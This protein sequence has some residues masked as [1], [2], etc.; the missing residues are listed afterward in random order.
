MWRAFGKPR[1]DFHA[2]GQELFHL[3][4]GGTQQTRA[5]IIFDQVNVDRVK[6]GW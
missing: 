2:V 5:L 4:G 6:A 3:R 1:L